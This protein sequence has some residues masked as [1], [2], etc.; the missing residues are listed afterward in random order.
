VQKLA[1]TSLADAQPRGEGLNQLDFVGVYGFVCECNRAGQSQSK[2]GVLSITGE[3]RT[4]V[5]E[6][7]ETVTLVEIGAQSIF[8][9]KEGLGRI[10]TASGGRSSCAPR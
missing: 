6:T 3:C 5:L 1:R 7:S 9:R 4:D 2:L 8:E 10:I